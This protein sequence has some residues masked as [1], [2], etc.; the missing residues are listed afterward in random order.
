MMPTID[1]WNCYTLM[2][3][4]A[5]LGVISGN[6]RM[7]TL[8]FAGDRWIATAM[9]FEE[10]QTDRDKFLDAID[11][12]SIFVEDVKPQLSPDAYR[13]IVGKIEVGAQPVESHVSND[14]RTIF[15]LREA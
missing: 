7:V 15:R 10:S 5:L 9:L 14:L 6:F 12:F 11:E 3:V 1:D 13:K 4:Q 2:L 8:E